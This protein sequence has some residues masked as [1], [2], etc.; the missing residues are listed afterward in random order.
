MQHSYLLCT[1][2]IQ[3]S[4]LTSP[5]CGTFHCIDFFN[6]AAFYICHL[7]IAFGLDCN[8]G[9]FAPDPKSAMFYIIN[10]DEPPGT[11]VF[12]Y[13]LFFI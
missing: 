12:R 4:G 1:I 9:S 5:E 11:Q 6:T 8:L 10:V 3:S 7:A 13:K 2:P